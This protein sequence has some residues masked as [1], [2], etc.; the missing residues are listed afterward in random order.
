[1]LPI[2]L[3]TL[4]IFL[5]ILAGYLVRRQKLVDEAFNRQL[6]LLLM[7]VFYPS[8]ILSSVV[9][10]YTISSLAANWTLPAGSI[11]IML[12]GWSL[13]RLA[14]SGL[15]KQPEALQRTFLFQCTMNNYSFL[16]IML[17]AGLFGE[18]AV[19][20]VVF[21]AFGAELC[22]WTLG[23]QSLTGEIRSLR[24]FRN[25]LSMPM[26]ALATAVAILAVQAL[27]V[28]AP[29]T[30]V[31]QPLPAV[32]AFGIR[33]MLLG[34]FQML[35]QATIPIS[36]IVCGCRMASLDGDN[37]FSRPMFGLLFLRL[38]AIPTLAILLLSLLPLTPATRQVLL[39]IAVQPTAMVSV[40][41]AEIYHTDSH[42]A[43]TA[44]L[45]THLLCLATIPF[46]LHFLL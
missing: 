40:T 41:M 5:M 3:K 7:N 12:A 21:A 33:D 30:P 42:F 9:R 27:L 14:R 15:H 24:T 39:V 28:P 19:A 20:Q 45:T 4:T 32:P 31:N 1:M 35:G 37:L 10:N 25:L 29:P 13:G 8:L 38:L 6:S 23:V 36:A 22:M 2:F 46:W 26:A 43:A 16:P 18:Q 17:V 11:L 34:A 44:V